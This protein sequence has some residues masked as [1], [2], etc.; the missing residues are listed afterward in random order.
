M[1]DASLRL[2]CACGWE[3]TG[4]ENDVVAAA[5]EHGER[6]HNMRPT[7]DEVLAMVVRDTFRFRASIRYW[8]PEKKTGLAVADIPSEHIPA[9]GGLKQQ[10]VHGTIG[11]A[12]F[13]SNVM[14]AGGGRLALS[15]SKAMM[16]SAGAG[17]GADCDVEI[18]RVG[19]DAA[20]VG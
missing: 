14:P 13:T 2:R 1:T 18:T 19:G 4:S 15:I 11:G 20:T 17:I 6:V 5:N 9:M 10:R 3:T 12:E 16:T 7:R 8:N